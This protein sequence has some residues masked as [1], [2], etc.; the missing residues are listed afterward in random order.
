MWESMLRDDLRTLGP[1]FA[2]PVVFIQGAED[3]LTVTAFAKEYFDT[4][5]AP[6][7][8]FVVLPEVG[9]LAIFTDP[10]AFLNALTEHVRPLAAAR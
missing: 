5:R 2:L 1:R 4:I 7:K 8:D 6:K 3:R 9:H 10:A